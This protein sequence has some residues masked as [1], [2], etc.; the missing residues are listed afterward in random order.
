M[1]PGGTT[2]SKPPRRGG[3]DRRVL[4]RIGNSPVRAWFKNG[5]FEET[6]GL[7]ARPRIGAAL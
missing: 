4:T 7:S 3:V 6:P 5:H 1:R 2:R